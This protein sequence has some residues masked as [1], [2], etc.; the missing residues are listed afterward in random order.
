MLVAMSHVTSL[1]Y[2]DFFSMWGLEVTA[3]A[4]AQVTSFSL[5]A[6]ERAFF[7]LAPNDHKKGALSTKFG[8]FQKITLNGTT[9]WPLP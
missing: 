1:D 5:P 9:A 3:K 6:V 4:A 7:A 8:D 2:V